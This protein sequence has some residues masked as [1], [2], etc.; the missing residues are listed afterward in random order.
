MKVWKIFRIPVI[1]NNVEVIFIAEKNDFKFQTQASYTNTF[2]RM[3]DEQLTCIK[4]LNMGLI[5]TGFSVH[6]LS[7]TGCLK[8][9]FR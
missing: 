7:Y 9:C 3:N 1:F 5:D 6:S 4:L 8:T 2:H